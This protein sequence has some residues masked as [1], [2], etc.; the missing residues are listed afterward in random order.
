MKNW[1]DIL[2]GM[3]IGVLFIWLAIEIINLKSRVAD[4]EQLKPA[5]YLVDRYGKTAVLQE[6]K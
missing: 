1:Q 3:L 5:F 4:L 6:I 2:F